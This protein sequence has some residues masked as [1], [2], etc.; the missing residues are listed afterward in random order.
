M[1]VKVGVIGVGYLGRHHARIY[2]GM[3]GVE[4][5]GI[6]DV[7]PEQAGEVA[8]KYGC[9]VYESID[10]LIE[11][12]DALS[13]VTPTPFHHE[14]AMKCL[15]SGKDILVEKPV[16]ATIEEADELIGEAEKQGLILQVGHLER[17]NPAVTAAEGYIKE[18]VFFE[19]ER[20]SPFL[21]RAAGVDVTLDLMIH[22]I[23]IILSLAGAPPGAVRAV[24][25]SVLSERIDV[26]KAW[27]DFENGVSAL[28]TAGRLSH[29]KTRRL[30]IFQKD[31]YI[32]LDYQNARIQRHYRTDSNKIGRDVITPAN[33]E[34]LMEEL[35]D[36][37][38]CVGARSK[39]IVSGI[40]AREALRVAL[41][42][43][44]QLK[45]S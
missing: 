42:I 16:T 22:D 28:V 3:G 39:P 29:D 7:S 5:V 45:R 35:R 12:S 14:I 38:R 21:E 11:D 23:D 10:G 13:I 43:T 34:P 36:F 24:G 20:L 9:A 6:M 32:I 44:E 15:G 27:I 37:I 1:S 25:A 30:K 40:E 33:K 2:S 17:F 41:K 19:S 26:A 4:L 18:P 31:S 8:E